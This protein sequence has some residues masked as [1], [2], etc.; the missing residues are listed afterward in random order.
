MNRGHAIIF[1]VDNVHIPGVGGKLTT[2]DNTP[3]PCKIRELSDGSKHIVLKNYYT[4][5]QLKE[6]LSTYVHTLTVHMGAR[7]WWLNYTM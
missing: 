7:Y 6:V 5:K 4:E 1:M 2:E 3:D